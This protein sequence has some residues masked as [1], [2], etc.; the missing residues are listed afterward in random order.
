M[1]ALVCVTT[2]LLFAPARQIPCVM[3]FLA[4]L[5][6]ISLHETVPQYFLLYLCNSFRWRHSSEYARFLLQNLSFS[7]P[8]YLNY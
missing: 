8:L 4:V 6:F 7:S 5:G 3:L 1:L 2:R